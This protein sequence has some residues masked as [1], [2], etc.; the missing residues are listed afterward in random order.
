MAGNEDQHILNQYITTKSKSE[1][2]FGNVSNYSLKLRFL[3]SQNGLQ[4]SGRHAFIL[5]AFNAVVEFNL[6]FS[7]HGLAA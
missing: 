4:L 7:T 2:I 1:T 3:R 6:I 5:H